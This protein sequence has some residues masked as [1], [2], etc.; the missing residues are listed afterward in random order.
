MRKRKSAF[1]PLFI[2][3]FNSLPIYL[4]R[5][6]SFIRVTVAQEISRLDRTG[7]IDQF[8]CFNF[9]SFGGH[10]KQVIFR[11]STSNFLITPSNISR[12]NWGVLGHSS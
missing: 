12:A 9:E 6:N 1:V 3:H 8:F 2:A 7:E 4:R 11:V 10:S 5:G